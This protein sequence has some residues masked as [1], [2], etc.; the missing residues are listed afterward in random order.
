MITCIS[1]YTKNFKDTENYTIRELQRYFDRL[2]T[3]MEEIKDGN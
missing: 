1:G 3:Y 2:I